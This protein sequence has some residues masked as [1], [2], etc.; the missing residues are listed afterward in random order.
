MDIK[1]KADEK[2]LVNTKLLN[3]ESY[4]EKLMIQLVIE[5]FT[6]SKINLEPEMAKFI[7]SCLVKEYINEYQ[8][9]YL[10]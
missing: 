4:F 9:I 8:G 5:S 2:V 6:K 1:R 3:N 10:W 7:N